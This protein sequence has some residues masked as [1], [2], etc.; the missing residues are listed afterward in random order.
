MKLNKLFI[1]AIGIAFISSLLLWFFE[2]KR[3]WFILSLALTGLL[4]VT[5]IIMVLVDLLKS[6]KKPTIKDYQG[7]IITDKTDR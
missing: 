5:F 1:P 6:V 3:L 4:I 2:V 7:L